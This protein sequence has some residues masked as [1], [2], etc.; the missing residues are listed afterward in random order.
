MGTVFASDPGNQSSIPGWVI[1]KTQKNDTWG[2][3]A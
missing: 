2:R 3:L 1:P